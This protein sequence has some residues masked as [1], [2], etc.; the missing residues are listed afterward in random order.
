MPIASMTMVESEGS[1][2]HLGQ[3]SQHSRDPIA[4]NIPNP[5]SELALHHKIW[6]QGTICSSPLRRKKKDLIHAGGPA[7]PSTGD[8]VVVPLSK[9]ERL[10]QW[11]FAST[12]EL[13]ADDSATF[14]QQDWEKF[15]AFLA[16]WN[17]NNS[18]WSYWLPKERK[19]HFLVRITSKTF[20]QNQP[21]QTYICINGLRSKEDITAFHHILS[22]QPIKAI[23]SPLRICFGKPRTISPAADNQIFT[24]HIG[25]ND[26]TL[27]GTLVT[28]RNDSDGL[29]TVSTIGGV[30]EIDG[31][32]YAITTNY[33]RHSEQQYEESVT[34]F[35]VLYNSI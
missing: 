14:E 12:L 28:V 31:S 29:V 22:Q 4:G 5:P 23:Y 35:A 13:I 33:P 2:A 32:I 6:K 25:A 19:L 10:K 26:W 27:C 34:R 7:Q 11:T 20:S 8:S 16:S 3:R 9:V 30:V 24:A 1:E 21:G 18:T 17:R 15:D